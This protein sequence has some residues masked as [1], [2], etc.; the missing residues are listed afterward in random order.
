MS[1]D[2]VSL[3]RA[4]GRGGRKSGASKANPT[5][6]KTPAR[7]GNSRVAIEDDDWMPISATMTPARVISEFIDNDYDMM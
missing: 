1:V 3:T 2:P 4:S 5:K 6:P 7:K